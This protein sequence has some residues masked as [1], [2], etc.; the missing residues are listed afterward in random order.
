MKK[1]ATNHLFKEYT[2]KDMPE[3]FDKKLYMSLFYSYQ[4]V[5]S[6]SF[7][8]FVNM[9]NSWEVKEQELDCEF[10]KGKIWV[11]PSLMLRRDKL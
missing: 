4:C 2:Y 5:F 7:W 3:V 9:L 8:Y 11:D 6:T 10:W 1:I